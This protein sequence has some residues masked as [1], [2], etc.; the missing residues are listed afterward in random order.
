VGSGSVVL[1]RAVVR[2]G[3]LVGA[4]AVV[5][6]GMEVPSGAMALGVPATL[7]LVAVEPGFASEAVRLYVENGRRYR[8]QLRVWP[9]NPQ[10][11]G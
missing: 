11:L 3:A 7:R 1:H 9:P 5:P 10:T 8:H 4:N 2:T 6:N